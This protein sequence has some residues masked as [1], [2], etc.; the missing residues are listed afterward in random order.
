RKDGSRLHLQARTTPVFK[1]GELFGTQSILLDITESKIVEEELRRAQMH[2]EEL[3]DGTEGIVWESKPGSMR[4]SYISKQAERLLGYPVERWLNEPNF[5]RDHIHPYDRSM[6]VREYGK[7]GQQDSSHRI[8]YRMIAAD[9]SIVWLDDQV[10]VIYQDGEPVVLRGIMVDITER[11]TLMEALRNLSQREGALV[12][13]ERRRIAQELHDDYSQRMA[14]VALRLQTLGRELPES[15]SHQQQTLEELWSDTKLLSTDLHNLAY[16]LAPTSLRQMGLQGA[17]SNLCD[18]YYKHHSL[19]VDFVFSNLPKLLSET[20]AIALY[21]IVQEAL[22]NVR[23]HSNSD[24][25]TVQ[26]T[27]VDGNLELIISDSGEGFDTTRNAHTH[28]L[29]L[30]GMAERAYMVGGTWSVTSHPDK[31]TTIKVVI[32]L[33]ASPASET[34]EN[35][36]TETTGHDEK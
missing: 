14:L 28:N 1:K 3:I 25:A 16:E 2:I 35:P 10:S 6:V 34:P 31:G 19:P 36:Q 26:L 24:D 17:I 29:G 4:F 18:K 8:E 27:G 11:K 23:K 21:R 33:P 32:P 5:W 30:M 12:E 20:K 22:N 15:F 7:E 13:N 9:D